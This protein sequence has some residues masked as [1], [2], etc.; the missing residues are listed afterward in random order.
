[1]KI[2]A[3]TQSSNLKWRLDSSVHASPPA[4]DPL[5]KGDYYSCLPE[6]HV[7]LGACQEWDWFPSACP[8]GHG[9]P[10]ISHVPWPV[11]PHEYLPP[12]DALVSTGIRKITILQ[13]QWKEDSGSGVMHGGRKTSTWWFLRAVGWSSTWSWFVSWLVGPEHHAAVRFACCTPLTHNLFPC[14][15]LPE[16]Q[17]ETLSLLGILNT[18]VQ[19][20]HQQWAFSQLKLLWLFVTQRNF[21][22]Q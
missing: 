10:V 11:L 7:L 14:V 5:W 8:A 6:A 20:F 2:L 21:A 1:M 12:V 13:T 3:F 18:S 16:L 4:R 22:E 17:D 19:A 9:A 15:Q